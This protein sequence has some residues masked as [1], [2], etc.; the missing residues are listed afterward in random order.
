LSNLGSNLVGKGLEQL[1]QAVPGI[2]RVAVLWQPGAFGGRTEKDMLKEVEVAAPALGV[3]LQFVEA[4][5]LL[6]NDQGARG[7]SDC[8]AKHHADQ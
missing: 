2:S 8:A 4:R 3:R 6:G 7:C 1:T 5:G